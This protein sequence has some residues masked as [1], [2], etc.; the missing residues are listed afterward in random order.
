MAVPEPHVTAPYLLIIDT[1]QYAGNF[2]RQLTGFCTGVDDGTHGH[3]EGEDLVDFLEDNP[4]YEN[5]WE[6]KIITNPD[7]NGYARVCSIWPTPGRANNG[8]GHSYDPT[9]PDQVELARL[10][11]KESAIAYHTPHIQEAQARIANNDYPLNWTKEGCERAIESAN[12]S[13][14]RAGQFM[15]H[16]SYESVVIFLNQPPT[17]EDMKLFRV[18]LDDFASDQMHFGRRTGKKLAIK[19]I[20]LVKRETTI[21]DTEVPLP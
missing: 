17:A 2:E 7:D 9:D 13:I 20:R 8:L 14:E 12:A 4:E 5:T 16:P 15:D 19:N 11:A 18:R 10:M 1:D 21:V 3:L 6:H